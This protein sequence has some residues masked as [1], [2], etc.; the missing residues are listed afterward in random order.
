MRLVALIGIFAGIG[1]LAVLVQYNFPALAAWA[2]EQ[3]R[4]FQNQIAEAVYGLR[5]GEPGAWFAL[6]G[7]AGAY[8]FVHAVGPGHGKY[9]IG[10]VGL[11]QNVS[12]A[13][14]LGVALISSLAQAAWAIVLVYGG[15]HLLQ[16]SAAR[17]TS[18]SE[19]Y[20]AVISYVAIGAIGAIL[21][22]RGV[23]SLRHARTADHDHHHDDCGCHAHGPRPEDVA[24]L[25]SV[26]DTVALIASIAIRPCTGAIFLLV[27]AWQLDIIWAGAAAVITMG[28]GTGLLTS[29]VA[30]S[31]V[32][33]RGLAF[34][35]TDR[36]GVATLAIP[37]LQVL[38]GLLILWFSILLLRVGGGIV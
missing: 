25:T 11:G 33:A 1:L 35:S 17:L 14:L 7:A 34:A 16:L 21:I 10:G 2:V 6:L 28:I 5:A 30:V 3:Q 9:L 38:T 12:A 31:S 32:F 8:G 19:D 23:V 36:L 18:I 20:L 24:G 29:M 4:A 27:I 37:S 22:W 15:L 13:R 26:R